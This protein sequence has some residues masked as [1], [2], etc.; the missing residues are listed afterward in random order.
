MDA[1]SPLQERIMAGRQRRVA[2]D[3]ETGGRLRFGYER[4]AG[5]VTLARVDAETVRQIFQ[6]RAAEQSMRAIADTLNA[7]QRPTAQG[8]ASWRASSVHAILQAEAIY[9]GGPRGS[10]GHP[11]PAILT[12]TAAAPEGSAERDTADEQS[13]PVDLA[14]A[15]PTPQGGPLVAVKLGNERWQHLSS[16]DGKTLCGKPITA[17]WVRMPI[18]GPHGCVDCRTEA[19]RQALTCPRCLRPLLDVPIGQQCPV[20]DQH[21][22]RMAEKAAAAPI[23]EPN[24]PPPI[25]QPAVILPPDMPTILDVSSAAPIVSVAVIPSFPPML[26]PDD[27]DAV[28]LAYLD[29][30]LLTSQI[31]LRT[32]RQIGR[33]MRDR[34]LETCDE[35][36]Q[37]WAL[38]AVRSATLAALI[39][40]REQ[41]LPP[42]TRKHLVQTAIAQIREQRDRGAFARAIRQRQAELAKYATL[43]TAERERLVELLGY[44]QDKL[45]GTAQEAEQRWQIARSRGIAPNC[46]LRHAINE[47][48]A[49]DPDTAIPTY[50]FEEDDDDYPSLPRPDGGLV[51]AVVMPPQKTKHLTESG[52]TTLC[53]RDI[54]PPFERVSTFGRDGCKRCKQ[55]AKRRMLCC[56]RCGTP[57]LKEDQPGWCPRCSRKNRTLPLHELDTV[58]QLDRLLLHERM[59]EQQYQLPFRAPHQTEATV[60]PCQRCGHPLLFLIFGAHATDANGLDAYG[61]LMDSYIRQHGLPA[62]VLGQPDAP[63]DDGKSLLRR[64]WPDSGDVMEMTPNRWDGFVA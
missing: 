30:Q 31:A 48:D 62:Y 49:W 55:L 19:R 7:Q 44:L 60:T 38:V 27:D 21:L 18:F 14:P 59:L 4:V 47:L 16:G 12:N 34:I 33:N 40:A 52:F 2:Q 9:R 63:G 26:A 15:F 11:W 28:Y 51:A 1:E 39:Q 17:P 25:D 29:D 57:L 6:L 61:R 45:V 22:Q 24:E 32:R 36:V 37:C 13:V 3:G 46:W 20:C 42:A 53:G 58:A 64:V 41:Q 56:F 23:D 5:V 50:L 54:S 8:A 43:P 10:S 35:A